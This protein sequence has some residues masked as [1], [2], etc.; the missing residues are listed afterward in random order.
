[1]GTF[2]TRQNP[3]VT[4]IPTL[5]GGTGTTELEKF[6]SRFFNNPPSIRQ[7]LLSR[8]IGSDRVVDELH[9]WF[10]HTHDVPWML[11]GIPPTN[12]RVEVMIVSIVAFRGGK[13]CHEHVYWD[14]ASVLYQLGLLEPQLGPVTTRKTGVEKL[15]VVGGEA[16]RRVLMAREGDNEGEADNE[17]IPDWN[18]TASPGGRERGGKGGGTLES[19]KKVVKGKDK[20]VT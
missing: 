1:M 20:E 11:P 14:Q 2:V 19:E 10:K 6:Y 5:T 4:H 7:T 17:L 16:A 8:T 3:S 12:R 15:P 9:V 13:I 18:G